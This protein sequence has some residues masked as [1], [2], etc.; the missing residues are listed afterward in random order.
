[1][2][3]LLRIGRVFWP[4][5]H[6]PVIKRVRARAAIL[7]ADWA[8]HVRPP[9]FIQVVNFLVL[10]RRHLDIFPRLWRALDLLGSWKRWRSLWGR[11]MM[12]FAH[13]TTSTA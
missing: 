1:M 3:V 10:V 8:T 6:E 13:V 5:S 4:A 7:A 2:D 12:V 9:L 11:D